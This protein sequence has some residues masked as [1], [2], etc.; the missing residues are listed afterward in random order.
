LW[1]IERGV[2]NSITPSLKSPLLG[3]PVPRNMREDLGPACRQTGWVNFN[4]YL[5]EIRIILA[6]GI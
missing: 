2:S 4:N 3:K 6:D 5:T 1:N